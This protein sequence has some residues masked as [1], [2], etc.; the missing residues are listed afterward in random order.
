MKTWLEATET[1]TLKPAWVY[2][3]YISPHSEAEIRKSRE[4]FEK[5]L[6]RFFQPDTVSK[7]E[8]EV[9]EEDDGAT[10][11]I[12]FRA[13]K[14]Q[15]LPYE[16][17]RNFDSYFDPADDLP[18]LPKRQEKEAPDP[19][20]QYADYFREKEKLR[21][22]E[23]KE[24]D[25]R[26]AREKLREKARGFRLW[27]YETTIPDTTPRGAAI[28]KAKEELERYLKGGSPEEDAERQNL[29]HMQTLDYHKVDAEREGDGW[30]VILI[31]RGE[32]APNLEPKDVPGIEILRG[33][34][35][36]TIPIEDKE[37]QLKKHEV[38][39]KA[40]KQLDPSLEQLVAIEGDLKPFFSKTPG[41][42]QVEFIFG[43]RPLVPIGELALRG[44]KVI[45]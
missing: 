28:L 4:K 6:D 20:A 9:E 15:D 42:W 31:F 39:L 33:V 45:S 38:N 36:V 44:F 40:A 2:S 24:S 10:L 3:D 12:S 34:W 29:F 17:E 7:V 5:L 27:K 37:H 26:K 30:K 32:L 19:L 22:P 8:A 35:S 11:T 23:G 13:A 41:G 16:I 18:D 21:D 1:D 25:I 43:G 14:K